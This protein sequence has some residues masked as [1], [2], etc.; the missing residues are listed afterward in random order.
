MVSQRKQNPNTS[1]ITSVNVVQPEIEPP[2]S[3]ASSIE[4]LA[5]ALHE[6]SNA[7]TV[8]LGW[9]DLAS[10]SDSLDDAHEAVRVALEHAR[11]GQ[12][13]ARRSIGA[14]VD[15]SHESRTAGALVSFAATSV[16]P[17]A[18]ARR[19]EI[20]VKVG[21]GTDIRIEEDT[22]ALQILTNLLLNAIA[23]SPELGVVNLSVERDG[24]G[25]RFLVQ[26]QGP[27]VSPDVAPRIFSAKSSTRPGGVGIGLPLSRRL[28]RDNGGELCLTPTQ[29]GTCFELSW[30]ADPLTAVRSAPPTHY[31][32]G[33][34]GRRIL[35]IEDDL[36]IASLVELSLEVHGAQVLTITDSEQLDGVLMK[37]PVFDVVLLDLSPVRARLTEVLA[38][39]NNL[40]PDAPI[41]L[42]SGEPG[43]VPEEAQGRFASWVRKPF[44]M[45]HLVLTLGRLVAED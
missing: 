30:P 3:G 15:S 31:Q 11:R 6:V 27:G 20:A 1:G 33:L 37:R 40:A 4:H 28:A 17:Q 36:S 29:Q 34:D 13:M 38:R 23:F 14:K 2:E 18:Q 19:V 12:V 24:Q 39:L 35:V 25:V 16:A 41:V 22:Q 10:K 26:D 42:M 5:C 45:D 7:L 44:D 9:L 21:A 43:G 8:V 32:G